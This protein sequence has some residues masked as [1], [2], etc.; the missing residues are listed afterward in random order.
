MQLTAIHVF[1]GG[2]MGKLE[3]IVEKEDINNLDRMYRATFVALYKVPVNDY[4]YDTRR[5]GAYYTFK[6]TNPKSVL[7]YARDILKKFNRVPSWSFSEFSL[8]NNTKELRLVDLIEVASENLLEKEI[9]S[10]DVK[11]ASKPHLQNY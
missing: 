4:E 7:L 2:I 9:S 5:M 11:T 8:P 1:N 3:K 10:E 6:A